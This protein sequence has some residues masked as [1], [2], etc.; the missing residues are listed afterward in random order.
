MFAERIGHGYH[1]LDDPE[2]YKR[3]LQDRIHF[4][5]CPYSSIMTGA[6]LP[7]W[8]KHPVIRLVSSELP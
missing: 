1:A 2:L 3:L 8:S 6:C 5:T 7:D 4:E